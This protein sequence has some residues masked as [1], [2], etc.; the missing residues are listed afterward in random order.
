MPFSRAACPSAAAGRASAVPSS[1]LFRREAG[2]APVATCCRVL[3]QN[4]PRSPEVVPEGYPARRRGR[5]GSWRAGPAGGRLL[6]PPLTQEKKAPR[7][8]FR[9]WAVGSVPVGGDRRWG[10]GRL[11]HRPC[12]AALLC[13]SDRLYF[14]TLR[15]KPKS[16]VN[17]HYFCTDEELVYEK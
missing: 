4:P 9:S 15:N 8:R 10:R 2:P 16:T 3:G 7:R 5:G 12:T 1:A 13:L 11:P 6:L 17:T 14:A